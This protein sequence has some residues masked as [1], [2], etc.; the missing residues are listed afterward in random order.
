MLLGFP[1]Y[2]KDTRSKRASGKVVVHDKVPQSN[3]DMIKRTK[4]MRKK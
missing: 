2:S 3:K 4:E 1:I